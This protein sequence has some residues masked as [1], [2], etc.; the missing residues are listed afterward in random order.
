MHHIST[1]AKEVIMKQHR[2]L[3]MVLVVMAV[4]F[5][6]CTQDD[7]TFLSEKTEIAANPNLAEWIPRIAY[8][9]VDDEFLVVWTEQGV[10]E[11]GGGS[12]YGIVAQR[13]ES[14]G[15]MIGAR[16]EPAGAPLQKIILLPTPEFNMFTKEYFIGYTMVG[17]GF[18]EYGAICNSSGG[19]V[20][21]PF[22]ISG[23]PKSQMH[24]RLAFN[25]TKHEYFVVYNSS[26]SGSPDIKG[27]ILA[28]DGT[29]VSGEIMINDTPGD[30]YNPFIAYNPHNDTYLLNWEDFRNVPTWEQNGEIYGALLDSAGNVLVNDI[31]MIDDFGT[32]NEGDQ[33]LNEVT[34]NP[35]KNQF[36]VCWT[37]TAPSLDNVG[38]RGRFITAGGKLAGPIFTIVDGIGPQIFPHAI[39]V[40]SR[41]SYFMMWEDGRNQENTDDSW[42]NLTDLDIYGKWMSANGR[43][44]SDEV[45]FCEEPGVQRY[46]S[47]SYSE[48]SERFLVTWQDI[49]DEDLHLGETDD[50]SGQHVK[51]AGGNVYAIAYGKP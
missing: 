1:L 35:D 27:V 6:A 24:T 49:V 45:T 48:Q 39:Y 17:D 10:R 8:N 41:K 5:T 32:S 38:I 37:D 12:L 9:S 46:S 51:E 33:R 15:D 47:I 11:P 13:F 21:Q 18:D 22:V 43:Q 34:Y 2:L 16:F 30:Q 3:A 29:P 31:P 25:S 19:S 28:E 26:E 20:K 44:F 36:L 7:M 4:C 23:Q 50:Q 14:S 40:P 42:R